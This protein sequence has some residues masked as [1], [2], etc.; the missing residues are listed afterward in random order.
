ML[1]K[2][3]LVERI[4]R[5]VFE[6][7]DRIFEK[8]Y[9]LELSGVIETQQLFTKNTDG[10]DGANAYQPVWC[11]NVRVLLN[12]VVKTGIPL[13]NFIDVG[14][15][16][17]KSCFYVAVKGSFNQII[18]IELSSSLVKISNTNLKKLP[19]KNIQFIENDAVK[20]LLP[21]ANNLVFLFNPFSAQILEKFCINNLEHFKIFDSFIAYSND[22]HRHILERL[23]FTVIFRDQI[24]KI[25]LYK[26]KRQW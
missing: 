16:K 5:L 17:G 4:K 24:R 3:P 20:Y 26:Y 9:G 6:L 19:Q 11:R 14:A 7:E 2:F 13:E 10:T 22:I 1:A 25:S 8:R 21:E 12:E 23:G 18:G 15:G